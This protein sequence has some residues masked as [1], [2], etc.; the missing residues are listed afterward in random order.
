MGENRDTVILNYFLSLAS[1]FVYMP[2]LKLR[3][4]LL[5]KGHL[6]IIKIILYLYYKNI[7]KSVLFI[8]K[9]TDHCSSTAL[10][11]LLYKVKYINTK[12]NIFVI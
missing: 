1:S 11:L 6:Y 10:S 4:Q 9:M 5:E 7:V 8:T 2:F 12:R 3:M